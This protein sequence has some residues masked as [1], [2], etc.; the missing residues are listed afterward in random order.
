MRVCAKEQNQTNVKVYTTS[1]KNVWAIRTC[2]L[3]LVIFVRFM[4]RQRFTNLNIEMLSCKNVSDWLSIASLKWLT[5]GGWLFMNCV[6]HQRPLFYFAFVCY[7]SPNSIYANR[8]H[9]DVCVAIFYILFYSIESSIFW[10]EFNVQQLRNRL[11]RFFRMI[12]W[13]WMFSI[14]FSAI[15]FLLN[16]SAKFMRVL[17]ERIWH[18]WFSQHK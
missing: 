2:G 18:V 16:S 9:F 14:G 6:T 12:Y 1:D 3:I 15:T 8:N 10:N 13:R 5:I 4:L 7:Q 11:E 17:C